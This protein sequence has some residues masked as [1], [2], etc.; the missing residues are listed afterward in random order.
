MGK[1]LAASFL[2]DDTLI[3]SKRYSTKIA[4]RNNVEAIEKTVSEIAG[5]QNLKE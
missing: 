2:Q 5:N 3:E 4:N 1:E